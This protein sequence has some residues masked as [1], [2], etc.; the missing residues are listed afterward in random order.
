M[1][2]PHQRDGVHSEHVHQVEQRG[3]VAPHVLAV[4]GHLCREGGSR[5]GSMPMLGG[6]I[7][8]FR[9]SVRIVATTSTSSALKQY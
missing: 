3:K 7:D 8:V 1:P 5:Q 2:A 6:W 4:Q 9:G